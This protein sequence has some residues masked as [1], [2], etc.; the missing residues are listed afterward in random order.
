MSVFPNALKDY[1]FWSS[2]TKEIGSLQLTLYLLSW[3]IYK[4]TS[5]LWAAHPVGTAD[6]VTTA[7]KCLRQETEN[8]VTS[9]IAVT[10]E[11]TQ[12]PAPPEDRPLRDRRQ[13]TELWCTCPPRFW[14]AWHLSEAESAGFPLCVSETL[15]CI[16]RCHLFLCRERWSGLET[17][18]ILSSPDAD[19]EVNI[20]MHVTS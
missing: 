18:T 12:S 19:S 1:Y 2:I 4:K 15:I 16:H 11:P 5:R 3:I 6:E 10:T 14:K 20:L 17:W 13:C 8:E 9:L 7:L